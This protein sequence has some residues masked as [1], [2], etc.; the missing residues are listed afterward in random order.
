M[1]TVST[2]STPPTPAG[3]ASWE[4]EALEERGLPRPA[5]EVT[6]VKAMTKYVRLRFPA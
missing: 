3:A 4:K 6:P 1:P 2:C 5:V